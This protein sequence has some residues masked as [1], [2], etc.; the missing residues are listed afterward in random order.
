MAFLLLSGEYDVVLGSRILGG[1]AIQGGMPIYKY[2]NNRPL[3]H[4]FKYYDG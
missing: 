2:I 1:K 3:K 4:S